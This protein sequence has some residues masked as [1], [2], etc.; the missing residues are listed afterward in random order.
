M[1][2]FLT[3]ALAPFLSACSAFEPA[4]SDPT[5][6]PP[7]KPVE[8]STPPVSTD[9]AEAPPGVVLLASFAAKPDAPVP[10]SDGEPVL[11]LCEG[12]LWPQ[13]MRWTHQDGSVRPVNSC[14]NGEP[15]AWLAGVSMRLGPGTVSTG[16]GP[17]T[18]PEGGR[19]PVSVGYIDGAFDTTEGQLT[20]VNEGGETHPLTALNPGQPTSLHW[21]G[22]L[23]N[24]NVPDFIVGTPEAD[25]RPHVRLFLSAAAD[26]AQ[27]EQVAEWSAPLNPTNPDD[28]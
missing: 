5:T 19:T 20:W 22:D 23:D 14:T 7:R 15:I 21:I 17:A 28:P 1:T 12:R 2:A 25:G 4:G 11:M 24:D 13:P 3:I 8:T 9:P 16:E 6:F 18:L 10:I 26:D 27:P